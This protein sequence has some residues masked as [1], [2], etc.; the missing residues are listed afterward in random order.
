MRRTLRFFSAAPSPIA[1][2]IEYLQRVDKELPALHDVFPKSAAMEDVTKFHSSLCAEMEKNDYPLVGIKVFPPSCE[3]VMTLRGTRSVCVP[4][5][6]NMIQRGATSIRNDRLQYVDATVCVEVQRL[7]E[8]CDTVESA[9]KNSTSFCPGIEV[10]G[11]RFP[12]FPPTLSAM[13][14][15]LGGCVGIE[16]GVP[17]PLDKGARA[18]VA[19]HRFVLTHNE[20]PVQVGAAKMCMESPFAAVV[21]AAE[22]V[23][24]LKAPRGRKLYVFCGG[25]CSRTPVQAGTYAFEWGHFG[26]VSYSVLP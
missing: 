8:E 23:K 17:V 15:D 2:Y 19:T 16:K 26:R 13:A 9:T 6:S 22:Y 11:S 4:I 3:A 25:V 20:E 14:C 5:F 10:S 12:F 21:A 24:A 7:V 1:T 18:L